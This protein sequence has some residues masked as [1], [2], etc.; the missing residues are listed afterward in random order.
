MSNI[1]PDYI[2][3]TNEI[4]YDL[5]VNNEESLDSNIM[6]KIK[7]RLGSLI[8]NSNYLE[9][10]IDSMI[11]DEF[12]DDYEDTRIWIAIKDYTFDKKIKYLEAILLEKMRICDKKE[13]IEEVK[14]FFKQLDKIRI[15]RNLYVHANWL[16]CYNQKYFEIKVKECQSKVCR[17]RKKITI[18]DIDTTISAIEKIINDFEYLQEVTKI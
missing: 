8:M 9:R 6:K 1:I 13:N 16:N 7:Y 17:L 5:E 10:V 14:N 12:S 3:D 2:D 11:I 18:E 4:L 15:E